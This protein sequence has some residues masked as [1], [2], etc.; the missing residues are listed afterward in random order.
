MSERQEPAFPLGREGK[1][2]DKGL[3]FVNDHLRPLDKDFL[4]QV[5]EYIDYVKIGLSLPILVEKSKIIERIRLYHDLGVKVQSGGT[6]VQVAYRKHILSQVFDRLKAMGFDAV[7]ISESAIEIPREVKEQIVGS[8]Q[9][10][11]IEYFFEV[12]KKDSEHQVPISYLISKIDEAI[13]LK[14]PKIVIEGGLGKS[15]RIYDVSGGIIWD[16]LNEIVGRF[17][18]PNLIFEAPL[19]TQR[20]A[21]ILEFGPNVNLAGVPL[22]SVLPLEMQRLGLT[23]ETLGVSPPVQNVQGSPAVKFVYHLIKTEHPIDQATLIQRSGLPKRTL[24]A[25]L[26]NLV[27]TGLI[28]EVPDMSD[29]RRHKYTPR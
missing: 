3:T 13:E 2:R 14:S 15:A 10:L 1:P 16:N 25:A 17:G 18:P 29:L 8:I 11:S 20:T 12:G 22:E 23:T 19:E 21:L 6:L 28:R 27:E 9:K 4:E 24:Q 5:A 7:E 26:S